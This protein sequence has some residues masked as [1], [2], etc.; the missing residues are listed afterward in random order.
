MAGGPGDPIVVDGGRSELAVLWAG[1]PAVGAAAGWVLAA[2]ADW[3]AE[4]RWIPMRGLFRLIDRLPDHTALLA[5][6]AV[7]VLGG[8]VVAAVGTAERVVVTVGPERVRLRRRGSDR[9]VP[10]RDVHTAYVDG[11]DLVLLAA[12]GAELARERT[13][14]SA[15]R[16]RDAFRGHGWRW[17]DADPHRDAYRRWVPDLPGLPPA[18][19]A[20]LRARQRALEADKGG[21]ARELRGE[22]ARC[23]VVVRDDGR[24]QYW[25]LTRSG[26][27]DATSPEPEGGGR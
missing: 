26:G 25:R 8:L 6:V 7:G 19:D 17:A 2:T 22:L 5:A 4:L 13:D 18:A 24:R 21:E 9:E 14:L 3:L 12:D 10:R 20:L 27:E 23:G 16:L 11:K 1:L 15:D